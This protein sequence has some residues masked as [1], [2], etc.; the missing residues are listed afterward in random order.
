M[1]GTEETVISSYYLHL[2]VM[3]AYT[4]QPTQI[5]LNGNALS[6]TDFRC[7]MKT[8][9]VLYICMH[10]MENSSNYNMW[11]CMYLLVPLIYLLVVW[12]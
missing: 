8:L 7:K 1:L 12:I 6:F 10:H 4:N 5:N 3:G 11:S 9:V 2:L